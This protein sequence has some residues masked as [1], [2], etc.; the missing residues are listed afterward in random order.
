MVILPICRS[1]INFQL[2]PEVANGHGG[3]ILHAI[4]ALRREHA[5]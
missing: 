2:Y 1:H 5:A 3:V 4:A